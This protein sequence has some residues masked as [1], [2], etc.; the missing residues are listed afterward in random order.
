MLK[1]LYKFFFH[2]DIKFN[3]LARMQFDTQGSKRSEKSIK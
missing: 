3:I 1:I 2:G